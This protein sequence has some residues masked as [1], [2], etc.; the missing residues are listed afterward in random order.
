MADNSVAKVWFSPAEH[1][2]T[3]LR[4]GRPLMVSLELESPSS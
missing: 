2:N 3:V 1:A 4:P